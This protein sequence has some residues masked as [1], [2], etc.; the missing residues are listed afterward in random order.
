M[1]KLCSRLNTVSPNCNPSHPLRAKPNG[2]NTTSHKSFQKKLLRIILD[3][4]IASNCPNVYYYSLLTLNF[5]TLKVIGSYERE[6]F[7]RCLG[8]G[9][10]YFKF[11]ILYL[12]NKQ[13]VRASVL[14]LAKTLRCL[15]QRSGIAEVTTLRKERALSSAYFRMSDYW[16]MTLPREQ[17]DLL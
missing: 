4:R 14:S 11:D 17:D 8:L 7:W 16:L 2:I 15:S 13:L 5:C 1:H 10:S 12:Q 6:S 9:N 3:L